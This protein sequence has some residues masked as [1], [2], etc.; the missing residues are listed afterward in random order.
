[1]RRRVRVVLRAVVEGGIKTI[2]LTT[3]VGSFQR[4][5]SR[6]GARRKVELRFCGAAAIVLW[7]HVFEC[8]TRDGTE[9]RT[10]KGYARVAID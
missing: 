9:T 7:V 1:M 6:A 5:R 2:P 4:M 10:H 8:V 3:S